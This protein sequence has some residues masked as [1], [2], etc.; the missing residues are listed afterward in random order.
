MKVSKKSLINFEKNELVHCPSK[1][2]AKEWAT[3]PLRDNNCPAD[4]ILWLLHRT[5]RPMSRQF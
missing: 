4:E 1:K 2:T 3:S 5:P